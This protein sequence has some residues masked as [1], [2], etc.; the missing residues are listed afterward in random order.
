MVAGQTILLGTPFFM[1]ANTP[2]HLKRGT[3]LYDFHVLHRAVALLAI[4]TSPRHVNLVTESHVIWKVVNLDPF[5]GLI[6]LVH[7]CDF[8]DVGLIG[9]NDL[10]TSHARV[11]RWDP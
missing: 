5:H 4:E 10:V 8:F 1:T 3:L 2:A 11:Q 9:R 6:L 7:L